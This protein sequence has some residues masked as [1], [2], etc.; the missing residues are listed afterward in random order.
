MTQDAILFND[1]V[2]GNL[3]YGLERT[4]TDDDVQHALREAYC[5]DFIDELPLGLETQI[6][7]RGVR[8]SGGQRQRL[9][10]AG[11]LLQDPDI[12]ILDEPTSALDSESEQYI[13][14]ALDDMRGTRTLIVIAHRLST[15]QRADQIFVVDHG[16]VVERGTHEELLEMDAAYR[17]LFELQINA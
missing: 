2:L 1:T 4:P 14:R 10:L 3:R 7:D 9:A 6:G 15:V 5:T 8:L 11:V 16:V 12:L 13:Q 17:K